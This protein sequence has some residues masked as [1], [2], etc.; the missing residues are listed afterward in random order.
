MYH[1]TNSNEYYNGQTDGLIQAVHEVEKGRFHSKHVT[2]PYKESDPM[3][4]DVSQDYKLGFIH[5]YNSITNA[6][7]KA[8]YNSVIMQ[9]KKN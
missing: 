9:N 8:T 4:N 1:L 3:F 2:A 6:V 7:C 5:A